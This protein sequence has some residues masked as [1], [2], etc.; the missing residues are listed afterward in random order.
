MANNTHLYGFRYHSNQNGVSC[1]Q[2]LKMRVASGYQ[3]A[4]GGVNVDLNVGDPVKYVNDGTVA[5]AAAGNA[6]FGVI[7]GIGP[8]NYSGSGFAYTKSLP[9]GTT[10]SS[11]RPIYVHVLPVAGLNFEVDADD[12]T[13][14]TTEAAYVAFI[15]ENCDH[16]I[17]QVS[18]STLAEPK[19]DISD[20]QTTTAQWRIVDVTREPGID[21]SG[22]NVRLIVT[23]NEVQQAPYVTAGV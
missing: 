13:T 21:F 8:T 16:T 11:A 14:A 23:C 19:L 12:N 3:A 9:G 17:N 4:P 2:P 10:S 22:T 6:V 5:L 1:P 15:G 7:V 20:H 18:G